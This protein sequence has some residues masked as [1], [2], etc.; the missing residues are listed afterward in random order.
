MARRGAKRRVQRVELEWYGDDFV[1]IVSEAG[2]EALFAAGEIVL[3]EARRRA[4]R[5]SGKLANSGYVGV[6]GRSTYVKRAYWR[7][8]RVARNA[9]EAVIG[10]TAPH[11]H[12]IES[13]RRRRGDIRPRGDVRARNGTLRR[14]GKRAL[15]INGSLRSRSR[16]K[17]VSSQPFL[18]PALEASQ[19][20]VPQELARI[21]RA[22]LEQELAP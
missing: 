13:G 20:R 1:T 22:R 14:S 6:K 11:A 4:P 2:P 15:V 17:R 10:F 19:E 7:R 21:Y 3:A 12:L 8:E 16:Y 18:G 5:R 9:A